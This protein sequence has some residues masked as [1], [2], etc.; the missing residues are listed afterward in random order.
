MNDEWRKFIQEEM[1]REAELIMQEVNSDPAMKDVKAPEGM[2]ESLMEQIREYEEEQKLAHLTEEERELL[3][4]GKIYRKRRKLSRWAVLIAAAVALFAIGTVSMGEKESILKILSRYLLDGEQVVS[5][6]GSVEPIHYEEEQQVF[7]KIEN[8]YNFNPVKLEY[9]PQ[10]IY[11]QEAVFCDDLQKINLYYGDEDEANIVYI[12]KPHY[13]EA[14]Y[15]TLIEDQLVQDYDKTVYNT[16]I[17]VKEYLVEESQE[18]RW[19]AAW[20]YNGV[21]YSLNIT[22]IEQTEIDKIIENLKLYEK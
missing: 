22:N 10:D 5:D 7:E 11:F 15:A 17:S 4:L 9:L 2:Y 16:S 18:K 21:Q 3:R 1:E 19:V 13:R 14:S 6:S 12:I 20:E 8:T